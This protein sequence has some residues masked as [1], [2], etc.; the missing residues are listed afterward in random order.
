MRKTLQLFAFSLALLAASISGAQA[1]LI[2]EPVSASTDMGSLG[3]RSPN[4]VRNQSGLS[5]GYTSLV[6]DFPSYISSNPTHTA[7]PAPNQDWFSATGTTTGVFDFNLGA[8]YSVQSLALWDIG[9]NNSSSLRGFDLFADNNASFSSATLL[10]HFN[11][12]PNTGP[13]TASKAEVFSFTRTDATYVRMVITSNNGS[14]Q[15]G[16]GEA[17]FEVKPAAPAFVLQ[18]VSAS[19]NMGSLG[20]RSPN[21]VRNQS[22]LSDSYMS[23]VTDFDSYIASDPTHTAFPAPNQD[24]FSATGTRTGNVDFDLGGNFRIDSLALWDIGGNNSSSLRGFDL[25]ADEDATFGSPTLLGHFDANPNTGPITASQAEVF[26]FAPTDAAWVRMVITS[27][28][29]S[30]QTG[31]GELAFRAQ[32]ILPP[33]VGVPEPPSI[34]LML[35]ALIL[36]GA[37]ATHPTKHHHA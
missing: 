23:L 11:A 37:S 29:G 19:T 32:F 18:P 3:G 9:G 1:G 2:L 10:G 28:N 12:N 25:L 36:L 16:F 14:T 17:A 13:I 4:N 6:T 5:T 21:N 34:L 26:S 7:F 24:W 15:T 8:R 31:F 27:N 30:T 20:G 22:G 35:G 33:A